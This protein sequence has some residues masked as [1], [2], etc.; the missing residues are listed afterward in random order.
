MTSSKLCNSEKSM[1]TLCHDTK[2]KI[3]KLLKPVYDLLEGQKIL[4]EGIATVF[5][6]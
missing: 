4:N 6:L 3:S 5:I 2:I 1:V